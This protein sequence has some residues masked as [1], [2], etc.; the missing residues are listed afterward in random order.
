MKFWI[1]KVYWLLR[2]NSSVWIHCA[3]LSN[4][5]YP[6]DYS[7]G[8]TKFPLA[9]HFLPVKVSCCSTFTTDT[10]RT[11]TR[12]ELVNSESFAGRF[13]AIIPACI[14]LFKFANLL[15]WKISPS[16]RSRNSEIWSSHQLEVDKFEAK[17]GSLRFRQ[18]NFRKQRN[19]FEK[20]TIFNK[21]S[22]LSFSHL[23]KSVIIPGALVMLCETRATSWVCSR[24]KIPATSY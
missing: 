24:P 17:I 11:P 9:Y 2:L 18:S 6:Y 13:G 16:R 1:F 21:R 12:A 8:C 14:P 10:S 4:G 23:L 22:F 19:L 7:S 3:I 15:S 5:Q 20:I